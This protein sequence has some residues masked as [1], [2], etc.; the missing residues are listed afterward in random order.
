MIDPTAILETL[1]RSVIGSQIDDALRVTTH[2]LYPSNSAVSVL[3]R[4]GAHELIVSDD[5]GA[6]NELAGVGF[7]DRITDRQIRAL[8][9][10]QGLKVQDGAIYSPAV[11]MDEAGAAILLV[12][13]ASKE[14]ADWALGHLRFSVAR[15]FKRDLA[16][17]LERHFHDNLKTQQI[18]GKSNKSHTFSNVVFLSGD[19]RLLIDPAVNDASSINARVVANLDVR[20]A[21]DPSIQQLIVYD[22]QLSWSA[23]DLNL[24]EVGAPIVPF[25][26]AEP[27]IVKRA[28]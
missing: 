20:L 11:T 25:S 2:C 8:V 16:L 17:L 12:A 14:I 6:M 26:L 19:R 28:A 23:S 13:N 22:D 1:S 15:D 21:N 24:L 4:G 3:L 27:A 7:R 18:V 5:G 9:K 10:Q